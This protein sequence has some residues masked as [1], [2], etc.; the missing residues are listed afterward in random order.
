MREFLP[1][2]ALLKS[3]IT[4][5]DHVLVRLVPPCLNMCR[6]LFL[7][8]QYSVFSNMIRQRT[9]EYGYVRD[10]Y[11]GMGVQAVHDWALFALQ[12]VT[13]DINDLR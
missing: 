4:R 3:P 9:L 5:P 8:K 2:A 7:A 13:Q 11:V 10:I 6:L 12:V 1:I